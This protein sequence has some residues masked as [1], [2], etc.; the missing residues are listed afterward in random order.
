MGH[1]QLPVHVPGTNFTGSVR[2]RLATS[3]TQSSEAFSACGTKSIINMRIDCSG[4]SRAR[5][6]QR[7]MRYF[8]GQGRVVNGGGVGGGEIRLAV[9]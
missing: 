6:E 1:R 4:A 7:R 5:W 2:M 8:W 3:Q 9:E